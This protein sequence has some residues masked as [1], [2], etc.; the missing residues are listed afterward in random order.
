[1]NWIGVAL[2]YTWEAVR[3]HPF[4]LFTLV[5]AVIAVYVSIR[6]KQ[7]A[8]RQVRA[9]ERQAK[10]AEQTVLLQAHA[11]EVQAD[12][13]RRALEIAKRSARS[14][15]ISA[16]AT[17][18]LAEAGQRAWLVIEEV[19]PLFSGNNKVVPARVQVRYRNTGKT[20]AS[21]ILMDH[22]T[23]VTCPLPPDVGFID[24]EPNISRGSI[25]AGSA[26]EHRSPAAHE[27]AIVTVIIGGTHHLVDYG[28][29]WYFD[30]FGER[31]ETT[32]C[33]KWVQSSQQFH[34][35]DNRFNQ[36]D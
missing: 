1:M 33:Y 15:E 12:D 10:A 30:I 4:N 31:H 13:T 32:W 26:D 28:R 21:G 2:N 27:P 35:H 5:I 36:I 3:T 16:E 17:K 7:E 11:L 19:F 8:T 22:F 24:A 29:L 18:A 14:A 6:A 20:P 23:Q 34:P 25:G 9:S